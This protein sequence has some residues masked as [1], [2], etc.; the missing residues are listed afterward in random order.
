VSSECLARH[1]SFSNV[2][3]SPAPLSYNYKAMARLFAPAVAHHSN[4]KSGDRDA[5]LRPA[6][7]NRSIGLRYAFAKWVTNAKLPVAGGTYLFPF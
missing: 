4:S 5:T 1:V 7:F 3:L 2:D 6:V